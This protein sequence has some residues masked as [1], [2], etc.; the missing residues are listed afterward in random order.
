MERLYSLIKVIGAIKVIRVIQVIRV[1]K[2]IKVI[3]NSLSVSTPYSYHADA[4]GRRAHIDP[5]PADE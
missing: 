5:R 3:V 2:V 1:I 4:K